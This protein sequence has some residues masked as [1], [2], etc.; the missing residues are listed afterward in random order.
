MNEMVSTNLA[1]VPSCMREDHARDLVR[2]RLRYLSRVH[3]YKSH[4]APVW[5]AEAAC[6]L[7][8]EEVFA[9]HRRN[10][11]ELSRDR[12]AL[13]ALGEPVTR[14]GRSFQDKS[15]LLWRLVARNVQRTGATGKAA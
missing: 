2:T 5:S 14:T 8:T 7:L 10:M 12:K 6:Y 4:H 1:A 11:S 13:L 3:K 15:E 9:S